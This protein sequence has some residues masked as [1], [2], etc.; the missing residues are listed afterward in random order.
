MTKTDK[1]PSVFGQSWHKL[2]SKWSMG[3][4]NYSLDSPKNEKENSK[5]MAQY[6]PFL[7][8]FAFLSCLGRPQVTEAAVTTGI[9]AHQIEAPTFVVIWVTA[10]SG[11]IIDIVLTVIPVPG[12][13]QACKLTY[14]I[15]PYGF[16]T[17]SF[18][19]QQ[20]LFLSHKPSFQRLS[21][22]PMV[23]SNIH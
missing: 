19:N 12:W 21:R 11:L 13:C 15:T 8:A 6:L 17:R 9:A 1:T 14:Y 20:I 18:G 3:G 4:F 5:S 23:G 16:A 22:C 7:L 10:R 2:A